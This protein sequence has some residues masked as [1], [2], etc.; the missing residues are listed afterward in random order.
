[1]SYTFVSTEAQIV[2][3]GK[4]ENL[5]VKKIKNL[6]ICLWRITFLFSCIFFENKFQLNLRIET[7]LKS[8]S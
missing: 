6:F 5:T 2:K 7:Y 4:R 1:M 8:L 3:E